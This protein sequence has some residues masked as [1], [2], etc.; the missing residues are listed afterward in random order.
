[1]IPLA[2]VQAEVIVTIW[3]SLDLTAPSLWHLLL[4]VVTQSSRR[5]SMGPLLQHWWGLHENAPVSLHGGI[6]QLGQQWQTC[7]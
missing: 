6:F 5:H 4:D 1:M 2:R 3:L 7:R